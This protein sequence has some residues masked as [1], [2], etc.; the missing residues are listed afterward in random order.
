MIAELV[1]TAAAATLLGVSEASVRRWADRGMIPVTRIG[2]RQDRRFREEDLRAFMDR[3]HRTAGHPTRP[4]AGP[5]ITLGGLNIPIG[6]HLATFYDSDLGRLRLGVPFLRDG[7]RRREYCSLVASGEVLDQYIRE[8]RRELGAELDEALQSGGFQTTPAA[9]DSASSG[10]SGREAWF[11]EAVG[12]GA[13]VLRVVGEMTGNLRAMGSVS[14][15]LAFEQALT[16]PV[17]RFPAVVI[18]QYDVR[19]FDGQAILAMVK[20]HPDDFGLGLEKLLP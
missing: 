5:T 15:L 11:W 7:I 4:D 1:S 19:D 17:K 9:G 13:T 20:A 18:C 16:M 14:E 3:G 12:S 6:S 2:P 8:L 10:V